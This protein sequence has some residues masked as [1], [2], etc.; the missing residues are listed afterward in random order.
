MEDELKIDARQLSKEAQEEK[1][2]LAIRLRKKGMKNIDVAK[3]VGLT[4]QTV[5]TYYAKYKKE[6]IK[7]LTS[8]NRGRPKNVGKTLSDEQEALI[9]RKLIDTNPTQLQFK[10]ALWT[11]EAVRQL[12]KHE[13]DIDM[14]ISTV[15]YYLKIWQFTSKKP[16][17]R[18]YELKDEKTQQWLTIEYPKIKKE[19]RKE[20]ADIWWADET[21]CQSLP[22]NLKGYAPIGTHNKP[23]LTHP[24]K[25][26]KIN[27][28]SAITNTSKSMFALYDESINI[29]RFI[30]FCKKVIDSNNG[31]KV[32]LIV[33]NLR[34]HH[35]KLVKAWE[36]ENSE[37]IKLF[38]LPPYSPEFNPDEYL[39]Q[40]YK[41]NANKNSLP[42]TQTQLRNNTQNYMENLQKNPTKVA[43]FFKHP[44]VQYAADDQAS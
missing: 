22:T 14:P 35:A 36:Q 7:A 41:R 40:D 6:G 24:A 20:K 23:V 27:M 16:I 29:D 3:I 26:F 34:V 5:S 42:M 11:R 37:Y 1:R 44:S 8:D 12:I 4:P 32:Y 25:K 9:K 15:G 2:K 33:D 31:K 13:F 43:N 17:K 21:H 28:I 10:F 38:Y 18:A 19:A 30:D 39:N